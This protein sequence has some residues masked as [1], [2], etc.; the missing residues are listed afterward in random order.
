MRRISRQGNGGNIIQ[1]GVTQKIMLC[2]IMK[3]TK[4]GFGPGFA[5][6]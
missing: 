5:K 1:E 3:T 6:D 4:P 2:Q